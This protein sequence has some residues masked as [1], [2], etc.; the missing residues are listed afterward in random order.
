M[1]F[2]FPRMTVFFIVWKVFIVLICFLFIKIYLNTIPSISMFQIKKII[3]SMF[4][5]LLFFYRVYPEKVIMKQL[6]RYIVERKLVFMTHLVFCV[7]YSCTILFLHGRNCSNLRERYVR[8][9]S[10]RFQ[11]SFDTISCATLLISLYSENPL[12]FEQLGFKF[13]KSRIRS[14][15]RVSFGKCF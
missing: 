8:Y 10:F 3:F 4:P 6:T 11:K 2:H 14:S 13:F 12:Q 9:L 5:N 15:I 7:G 1:L